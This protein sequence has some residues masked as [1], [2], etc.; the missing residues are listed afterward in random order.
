[1]RILN[2][3]TLG[4]LILALLASPVSA[5]SAR[6]K[7]ELAERDFLAADF[8][9]AL[10]TTDRLLKSGD[11]QGDALRDGFVLRARCELALGHRASA[12]DSFCAALHEDPRWKPDP[13][14]FTRDEVASF[15]HAKPLCESQAQ[16]ASY[17][18]TPV[19]HGTPWYKKKTVLGLLGAAAV[20]ATVFA[21]SGGDEEAAADLPFF[22]E[23][24]VR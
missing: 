23:A 24:P 20:T 22:P 8:A 14:L 15:E 4:F 11:L 16:R 10:E 13:L 1:M 3:P 21:L 9:S 2:A 7:L 18:P 5:E 19:S 6:E 17:L 12:D